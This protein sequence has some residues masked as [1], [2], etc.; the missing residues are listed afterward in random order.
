MR[1]PLAGVAVA[2]LFG[3]APFHQGTPQLIGLAP[4]DATYRLEYQAELPGDG[5]WD[6][7]SFDPGRS[8][9]FIG[10]PDGVQVAA[11]DDGTL[12]ARI[13]SGRGNHGAAPADDIDRVFTSESGASAI[14]VYAL[15]TLRRLATIKLA[16]EPDALLYDA[17]RKRLL[18]MS[19]E[20][21][22]VIVI[23]VRLGRVTRAIAMGSPVEAAAVDERGQV[24][25]DLPERNEVARIDLAGAVT[26]RWPTKPCQDPSSLALDRATHRLFVGCRNKLLAFLNADDGA[27]LATAPIGGGT[28]SMVFD[29]ARNVAIS[30]NGEGFVSVVPELSGSQLGPAARLPTAPAARTMA[31]DPATGRLFLA[32]ADIASVEPLKPGQ[33]YPVTHYVPGTFRL[34]TYRKR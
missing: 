17:A 15:S 13:G 31:A 34:L 18:V 7:V 5:G 16:S 11:A 32:T 20:G 8:L 10:R 33:R 3:C 26:A 6:Y 12:I 24:F 19:R 25:V 9:V 29:A 30:A 28:D 22:S 2:V 23:D 4:S 21:S 27:V 1:R 14:G